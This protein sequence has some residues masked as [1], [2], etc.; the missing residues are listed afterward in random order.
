[1]HERIRSRN[2]KIGSFA[3]SME[4]AWRIHKDIGLP[5][6]IR[7]SF[8]LGGTGGGIAY[9]LKE[10]EEI[11]MNGLKLSPTKELLD[12]SLVGWKEFEMEVVRDKNDNC[13]IVCSIENV[14]PMGVHTGDS[15]TVAPAQTLTD[16]EYQ[17]MR[18]AYFKSCDELELKPVDQMFNSPKIKDWSLG[19]YRNESKSKQVFR[20]GFESNRI[21]YYKSCGALSSWLYLG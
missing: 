18:D 7:P 19:C 17:E 12:E 4:D 1:M 3:H 21:S 10:F 20:I 15:I 13:I 11:C 6:V 2:T 16:K 9:N 5:C 14:D 8:T